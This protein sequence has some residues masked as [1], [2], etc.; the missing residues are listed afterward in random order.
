MGIMSWDL[1]GGLGTAPLV[2]NPRLTIRCKYADPTAPLLLEAKRLEGI[3]PR[4]S[5]GRQI[6]GDERNGGQ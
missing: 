4:G 6:R 5:Q 2:R 3:R 1:D